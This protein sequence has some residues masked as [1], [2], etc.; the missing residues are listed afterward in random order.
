[1]SYV[2]WIWDDVRRY[3]ADIRAAKDCE[4]VQR[5][6]LMS[7]FSMARANVDEALARYEKELTVREPV[8]HDG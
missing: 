7:R 6:L 5:R 4:A 1:M 2:D 3:I 8:M